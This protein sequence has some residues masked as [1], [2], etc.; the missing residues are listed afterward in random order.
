LS[1]NGNVKLDLSSYFGGTNL[2]YNYSEPWKDISWTLEHINNYN[3]TSTNDH[4]ADDGQ[5]FFKIVEIDAKSYWMC[6]FYP[7][8]ARFYLCDLI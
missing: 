1:G 6:I 7:S 3:Y 8:L 5:L 2:K 4:L